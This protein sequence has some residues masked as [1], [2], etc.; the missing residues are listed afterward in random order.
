MLLLTTWFLLPSLMRLLPVLLW[1]GLL[2]LLLLLVPALLTMPPVALA[3]PPPTSTPATSMPVVV[4]RAA[5][6]TPLVTPAPTPPS[7][8]QPQLV[9]CAGTTVLWW[10]G[11]PE[12]PDSL[13]L[14][15]VRGRPP[16]CSPVKLPLVHL[17]LQAQHNHKW[18]D[19]L[20]CRNTCGKKQEP[21]HNEHVA[22]HAKIASNTHNQH[23]HRE[24]QVWQ[25]ASRCHRGH[26]DAALEQKRA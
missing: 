4:T 15:L 1:L 21:N 25:C 8:L 14:L 6:P 18:Q 7:L 19:Q 13:Q 17:H 16:C 20:C 3:I 10:Q 26:G 11:V 9:S 2:P 23:C 5:M 24:R 22:S 12:Y